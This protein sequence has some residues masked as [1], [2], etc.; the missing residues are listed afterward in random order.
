MCATCWR[1]LG[2]ARQ[3]IL[4]AEAAAAAALRPEPLERAHREITIQGV[5]YVV[6]F[7][8]S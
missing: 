7:D 5:T 3:A 2:D 6:V 1:E 4:A 8:G